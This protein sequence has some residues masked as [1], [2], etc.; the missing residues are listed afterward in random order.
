M[1]SFLFLCVCAG[2]RESFVTQLALRCNNGL[3]TTLSSNLVL[4]SQ[5][6]TLA[7]KHVY[8]YPRDFSILSTIF[9][10]FC[11]VPPPMHLSAS[12]FCEFSIL[13]FLYDPLSS[14]CFYCGVNSLSQPTDLN[15]SF[16]R[17]ITKVLLMLARR[18]NK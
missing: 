5:H 8:L 13:F 17:Y 6:H 10:L 15:T 1:A 2:E 16:F 12:I 9:F 14:S 11:C 4:I 7:Y 3:R 18:K